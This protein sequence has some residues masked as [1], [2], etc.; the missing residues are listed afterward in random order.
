MKT[1]FRIILSI[2]IGLIFLNPLYSQLAL[3]SNP[4]NYLVQ[5]VLVGGGVTVSNISY[6]GAPA[7]V[8]EF[9]N[10]ATT[11]IGLNRGI[12]IT[13]GLAVNCVGPNS[14]GSKGTNNGFGSD[15][16]LAALVPGYTVY[17]AAVIKF[18]FVPF[19]DTVRFRYVFGSDEYPEY[20]GSNFNDVFGFFI[21]G[22]NPTGG[23]YVFHNMA[24]I[25]G[26]VNTPVTIN[27]VNNGTTNSGPCMN[28]AYYVNNIG[29]TT[30]EYDGFTT[31]LT[32]WAKVVPCQTY[33]FKIA[34]GDAGDGI[35][36]SGVFLE[37]GSFSSNV[38]TVSTGYTLA[39]A[40]KIAIEGCNAAT[41]T[42]TLPKALTTNHWVKIDSIYGTATN[43]V[44]F[45]TIPDSVLFTPGQKIKTLTIMPNA[46]G[47]VEGIEFLKLRIHTNVCQTDTFVFPIFDYSPIKTTSS[48]DTMV[49]DGTASIW[50]KPT[51]GA[52][53]Y[54]YNWTPPIGLSATNIPNPDAKPPNTTEYF[55]SISDST[56]CPGAID[57]VLVTVK[58]A[59]SISFMPNILSG[60][61]PLTVAFTDITSP[62]VATW[63]WDFG[64]GTTS[65]QQNPSHTFSKGTFTIKLGIT[66]KDGCTGSLT[67]NNL[68]TA[69]AKPLP[70]F[71]A[72]PPVTNIDNPLIKFNNKTLFGS[73]WLWEFGD[74]E[75]DTVKHAEHIFKEGVWNVCLTATSDKG[76]VDKI[77]REVMVI[78]DKV[79]IPNVITPNSDG[80][81]DKFHVINLEKIPEKQLVIFNRWGKQVYESNNYQNDWDAAGLADGVYY[82]ILKIKTYFK[83]LEYN[84]IVTV[85]RN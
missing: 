35:Y 44:D 61:E 5:N 6:T 3:N 57:S 78:V 77:C 31:V 80:K 22:P 58:P 7:A 14:S 79:E 76:C 28:C 84:G 12:V 42:L 48:N 72:N 67:F 68:I 50:V 53:P 81:N 26:T 64:D 56:T 36:D 39:T 47:I 34:I 69:F 75:T 19:G 32:A 55:V 52:P 16:Q 2:I 83:E 23:N 46:D 30:I 1:L 60:C 40:P 33:Q 70:Y 17:D 66:T 38:I 9:F 41:V 24:I 18:D 73:T 63:L 15:P 74:G 65:N 43:G 82:Y 11:N 45:P 85:F 62:A 25:P 13:S 4:I 51:G 27:N 49:C 37:E 10:G 59:P 20:S 8:A 71:D 29:G 54:I 21:S